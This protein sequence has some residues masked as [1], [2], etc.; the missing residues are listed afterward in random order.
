[1]PLWTYPFESAWFRL[2]RQDAVKDE[3]VTASVS[4]A[5]MLLKV[6]GLKAGAA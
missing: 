5:L 1:M 3:R 4:V 6:N 2:G